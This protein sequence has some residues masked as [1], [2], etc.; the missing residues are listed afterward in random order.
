MQRNRDILLTTIPIIA[1]FI[2]YFSCRPKSLLYYQ[3]IPFKKLIGLDYIHDYA[4]AG[5]AEASKNSLAA[6]TLIFSAPAAL[7]AFSLM[8]YLRTRYL[9]K[10]YAGLNKSTRLFIDL[11]LIALIAY[12][13]EYLQQI[14]VAPGH[15]DVMDILTA[16]LAAFL[17]LHIGE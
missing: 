15:F 5:C 13:P 4:A 7:Y 10:A 12:L 6:S 9:D 14:K 11:V 17:A 2:I 16:G 8:Y 3:W 1:G